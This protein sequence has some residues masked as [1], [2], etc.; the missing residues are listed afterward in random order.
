MY[1]PQALSHQRAQ[2]VYPRCGRF[3]FDMCDLRETLVGHLKRSGDS[4][5]EAMDDKL[6]VEVHHWEP[7][8]SEPGMVSTAGIKECSYRAC[9]YDQLIKAQ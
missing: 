9:K 5:M 8:L 4:M 3:R 1:Y 2:N 7:V 6:T